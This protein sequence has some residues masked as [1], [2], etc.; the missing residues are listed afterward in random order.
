M[1][2]TAD[3]HPVVSNEGDIY[4]EEPTTLIQDVCLCD[5]Q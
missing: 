1:N 4:D 3:T 2:T 5:D